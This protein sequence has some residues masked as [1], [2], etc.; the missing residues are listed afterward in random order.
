MNHKL[1]IIL[2]MIVLVTEM[3]YADKRHYVWTYD[4]Q[5]IEPGQ[6]EIESYY[7]ATAPKWGQLE[8]N[9]VIEQQVELEVGMTDRFDFG[10][11]GV[12]TQEPEGSLQFSGYKLRARYRFGEQDQLLLDPLLYIEYKGKPDFSEHGFETKLILAKNLG[13]ISFALNPTL[14]LE[15]EHGEEE[16]EVEYTLGTSYRISNSLNIGL[17]A[18][19]SR[20]GHY[21][22]PVISHGSKHLWVALGSAFAITSVEEYKPEFQLRLLVGIGLR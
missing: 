12:Y 19:G 18:K 15:M 21:I 10:V 3:L 9:V 8:N 6:G 5:T 11:Y 7:T 16:F 14:E 17:E 1:L 13:N 4:Y 2:I 22:G 20:D